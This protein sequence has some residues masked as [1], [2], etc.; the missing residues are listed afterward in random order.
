MKESITR[1]NLANY[2]SVFLKNSEIPIKNAAKAIGCPI[3]TIERIISQETF[4]SD[5]MLKQS[6]ILIS[7]GYNK[8]KKL[9]NADKEKISE[10]IGAVG[11]GVLGFGGISAAISAS[12]AVVGLSAAGI[13]SGLGAIGTI[14][15][16]GMVAGATVIAVI[17][18]AVGVAG[19]GA[20]KGIK[21]LI[22]HYKINDKN[23]NK[24]WEINKD[25]LNNSTSPSS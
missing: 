14:V 12:G 3:G 17:P 18:I 5:E 6:A 8:Y 13:T 19:Y 10:S 20:I 23:I 9:S 25:E 4:P 22:T 11:G 21:A 1:E 24:Y 16:G 2:L 7:I 15:G